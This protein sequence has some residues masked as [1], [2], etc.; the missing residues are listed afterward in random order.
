LHLK[1]KAL[2][3]LQVATI[4]VWLAEHSVVFIGPTG[5]LKKLFKRLAKASTGN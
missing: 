2:I 1:P 4:E 3:K 5:A